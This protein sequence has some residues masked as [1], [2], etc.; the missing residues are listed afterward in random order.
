MVNEVVDKINDFNSKFVKSFPKSI[1]IVKKTTLKKTNK[2]TQETIKYNTIYIVVPTTEQET[3]DIITK[4][5]LTESTR[6]Y[7]LNEN[8]IKDIKDINSVAFCGNLEDFTSYD[9]L[10]YQYPR[11]MV[12]I[13]ESKEPEFRLYTRTREYQD[14]FRGNFNLCNT[15]RKSWLSVVE[16]C[17]SKFGLILKLVVQVK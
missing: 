1:V 15:S 4:K 8:F 17:G 14:K 13:R 16:K 9:E 12:D 11:R 7:L 3:K 5:V 6:Q 10:V 2:E